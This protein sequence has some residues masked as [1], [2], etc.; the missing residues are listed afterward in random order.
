M[1]K[2]SLFLIVFILL[3]SSLYSQVKT[4]DDFSRKDL[5]TWIWGGVEMKYSHDE[6]NKEN[7]FVEIY[8]TQI[9][10]SSSYTG[11]VTKYS[12][13]L[14]SAGNYLNFM[15]QGVNNDATVKVQ[16]LYDIDNNGKYNDDK[17]ILL[18]SKPVT[19]NFSGWKEVKIK[20]DEDNFSIVSK[21]DDD[22]T[23]TEEEAI[24]IQ[25]EYETG[26]D[27]KD[28]KF[29]T[30]IALISEIQNKDSFTQ[31]EKES[32]TSINDKESYFNA[33]NYPNPFNPN[34]TISFTLQESSYIK[35]TVYDRLGRE[36]KTLIDENR[37]AG[38]HTTEFNASGL[39]S[40]IYFYRIKTDS[41]TEVRKMILA[42]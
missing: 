5:S 35:L 24:G 19:L 22:F 36:V 20:L 2:I 34:T 33:K 30:G 8:T 39:P 26:K 23:V 18:V 16:I 11:K 4:F 14:L 40:G 32:N 41:R 17:D 42:K 27:Y 9:M 21:F 12:P 31:N 7:G 6:D 3:S 13:L 37:N 10:K 29:T 1:Q 28:S 15:L 25:F 38:T